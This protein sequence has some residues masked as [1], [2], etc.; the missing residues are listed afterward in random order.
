MR[1]YR[2]DVKD[3]ALPLTD[4]GDFDV[5]LDR[6]GDA[7]IVLLG[8]ASHGTSEFY[9]WRA[10]LTRRLIAERRFSFVGV[11]GDW[12]DCDRVDRSV[13]CR[14]DAPDDPREALVEFERWPTWMW[15]NEEVVDFCQWLRGHNRDIDPALRV[16]LHGLDVYSL[17]ESLREIILYLR[18]H[19]P[20]EVGAALRAY[21]CFEPFGEDPHAYA[22]YARFLPEWCEDAVVELLVAA[23]ER[24]GELGD[25]KD[26]ATH[27]SAQQNAFVVADAERYYRAMIGG[28]PEAWNIRDTHLADTIDRLLAFYGP[29]SKAV[30]WAHNTHVGDARATDMTEAGMV[31][32]GQLTRE[33]YGRTSVA[34]LGLGTHGGTVVAATA[35]G[36]RAQVMPVPAARSGSLEDILHE[37]VP[38]QALFVFPESGRPAVLTDWLDH[39]AIGVVYH[40]E[41][42]RLGNYVPTRLGD[43]YDAF[44]WLDRTT[45]LHPL[46]VRHVD[47]SEPETYPAGV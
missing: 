34:I 28:G 14:D 44:C 3:L 21:R 22:T 7:R 37:H 6:I 30:I 41:R 32:L 16:G 10:A 12:P 9:R 17:W 18:E 1:R 43:R 36:D 5:L 33:R 15:A 38:D 47:V 26:A 27:F 40:P 13:R 25:A 39:R 8:E 45:G 2:D 24:A 20:G 42:E 29:G 4:P 19:A 11:E 46:H 23:R 35:W 31:N